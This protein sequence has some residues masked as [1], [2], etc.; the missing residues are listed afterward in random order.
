[1]P[2]NT[3]VYYTGDGSTT[4]FVFSFDYIDDD[5]I[6][7]TVNGATASFTL[8]TQDTVRISPAPAVSTRIRIF[9]TTP[10][11]PLITWADG[12][13][14][15]GADLNKATKQPSYLAEEARERTEE[16]LFLDVMGAY[17]DAQAKRIG[18]LAAPTQPA[19]AA[20]KDYVDNG[21]DSGVAAAAA[22]AA[23]AAASQSAAAA[24]QSAAAASQSAAATSATNAAASASSASTSASTATTKASEASASASSASTSATTATTKAAEALTS[25]NN[26]AASAA[27]AS[28][29]ASSAAA[30]VVAA[31]SSFDSFDDR[32]LGNKAADPTVDNDG[33]AL[34]MGA[35]Y[36][37]TG[38]GKIKIWNGSGWQLAFNDTAS[39]SAIPNDSGV[40]GANVAAALDT[41]NS[42]KQAAAANLTS[43]AALAP[44][45][46]QDASANLTSWSALAPCAKQDASANLTS[47]SAL[48]PSAKADTSHTH[49]AS[50][51]SDST[52]TGRSVV[53]AVDAAA[54][55]TALS[56]AAD[57]HTHAAADITS[58][59]LGTARLG[60]GTANSNTFLRGDSSWAAVPTDV[61]LGTVATTATPSDYTQYDAP[62]G[63]VL[64]G[65]TTGVN[66][67]LGYIRYKPLQKLVSGTWTT[68]SG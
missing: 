66:Q 39:A 36:Y 67:V 7:V 52:V 63:N 10:G 65:V 41:L 24:S 3:I 62:T 64:T 61:R 6:D 11:D 30:S 57:T 43:W 48:A 35:L 17:Y 60:S 25:A 22:S 56:A 26:A 29:S 2:T 33:N 37:N 46:K 9:R 55:R 45:S 1:M 21:L 15:L 47:W 27:A 34:V 31:A 53:T 12:A 23:A 54:G 14:I 51:I 59:T 50:Q 32:F 38:I 4:D 19:D 8:V 42:G 44:S 28:A 68:V 5:H 40:T 49:T 16:A 58:G 20:T 13:V 18:D